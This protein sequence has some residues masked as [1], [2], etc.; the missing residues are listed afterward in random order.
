[1]PKTRNIEREEGGEKYIHF[2]VLSQYFDQDCR[3][4]VSKYSFFA[5]SKT[6]QTKLRSRR[7]FPIKIDLRPAKWANYQLAE[8][9][10]EL[11]IKTTISLITGLSAV[12]A[13]KWN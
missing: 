10:Q 6:L 7:N 5:P 9:L 2:T 13:G 1:M 8:Q 12:L 4:N 11:A 3:C